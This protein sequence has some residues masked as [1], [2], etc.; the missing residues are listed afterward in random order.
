MNDGTAIHVER[1]RHARMK[2]GV[3]LNSI[4]LDPEGGDVVDKLVM[5]DISRSGI[6]A[7]AS[8]PFYPGQRIVL[9]LPMPHEGGRKNVYASI[10]QC[11]QCEGGYRVGLQ[12]DTVSVGAWCGAAV[13][14]AAA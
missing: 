11:R 14:A 5:I 1:R 6:G 2:H 12:F 7:I 10:V 4:R 3:T 8:R 13:A 9:S